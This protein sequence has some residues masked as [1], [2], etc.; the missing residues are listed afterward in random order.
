M[1]NQSRNVGCGGVF[2]ISQRKDHSFLGIIFLTPHPWPLSPM[3][4]KCLVITKTCVRQFI[5]DSSLLPVVPALLF[6]AGHINT[7]NPPTWSRLRTL[8]GPVQ[9]ENAKPLVQKPGWKSAVKSHYNVKFFLSSLTSLLT[10][11]GDLHLILN[12]ILSKEKFQ[13][14]I[15]SMDF[16]FFILYNVS[17]KGKDKSIQLIWNHWNY[18]IYIS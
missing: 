15:I 17:F 8:Q 5:G 10:C 3:S 1:L 16:S 4:G 14:L 2:K 18:T 6:G 11:H 12:A 7:A 9:N 13:I